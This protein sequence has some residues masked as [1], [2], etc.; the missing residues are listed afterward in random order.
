MNKRFLLI[1]IALFIFIYVMVRAYMVGMTHDESYS[2]NWYV[3]DSI[4]DIITYKAFPLL[5]NNHIF[6]TLGMKFFAQI[7]HH[8]LALRMPNL[9]TL[10]LMLGFSIRWVEKFRFPWMSVASLI[11]LFFNPYFLD[12]FGLARGYALGSALFCI[13]L[14]DFFDY[15]QK[16]NKK[17]PWT[18]FIFGLLSVWANFTLL[19]AYL[20]L[21]FVYFIA[22]LNFWLTKQTD[23]KKVYANMAWLIA[24]TVLLYFLIAGPI[25]LI[26]QANQLYGGNEGFWY[27]TVLRLIRSTMYGKNYTD[28]LQP[29]I[30]FALR[31]GLVCMLLGFIWSLSI[32]R[33]NFFKHS[34]PSMFIVFGLSVL[35]TIVLHLLFKTEYLQERTALFYLPLFAMTL[36]SFFDFCLLIYEK[37]QKNYELTSNS[38]F[39]KFV[40][41]LQVCIILPLILHFS[42]C[43]NFKYV[44]E[45]KYDQNNR[46]VLLLIQNDAA[47]DIRAGKKIRL[48]VNALF[49][50]SI[51]YYRQY[52]HLNWLPKLELNGI[53][54]DSTYDYGYILKKEINNQKK[55]LNGNILKGFNTTESVLLK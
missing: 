14:L 39:T 46:E 11:I 33:K 51:N 26:R 5:P 20:A 52:W 45:W 3:D 31:I 22:N 32:G 48:E 38:T 16:P 10:L 34:F 7:S 47:A 50:P 55:R 21:M 17:A 4:K 36:V 1:S 37:N 25:Q 29:Y 35:S 9:I 2:Y 28:S 27:D 30:A 43:I 23:L 24:I 44:H 15:L 8:A 54:Q 42:N 18:I 40:S 53:E 41:L 12:F 6:N 13:G 49:V 19:N